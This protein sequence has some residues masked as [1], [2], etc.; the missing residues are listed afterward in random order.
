MSNIT[1]TIANKTKQL[2]N[3]SKDF[4]KG[5]FS[6]QSSLNDL[7]IHGVDVKE[8]DGYIQTQL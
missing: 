5:F 6:K 8:A 1:D 4:V 2:F 3:K 7:N